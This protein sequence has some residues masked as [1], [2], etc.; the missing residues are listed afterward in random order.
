[1]IGLDGHTVGG[2]VVA[3][4]L[5]DAG[6]EVVYLG[7]NQTPE[8]IVNAA[9]QENVD[10]IGISSHASNYDQIEAMLDLLK[11]KGMEHVC[12]FCGGTIPRQKIPALKARGI[13][14]VFPPGST[15]EAILAFLR[16]AVAGPGAASST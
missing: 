14:E 9:V 5:R 6:V 16:S 1:M 7:V 3:R 4:M 8:M 11:K 12:V 2:E 10:A 15:S 13:A